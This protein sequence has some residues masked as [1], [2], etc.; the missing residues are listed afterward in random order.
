MSRPRRVLC[1]LWTVTLI[2]VTGSSAVWAADGQ[3]QVLV[4]YSTRRDAQVAVVGERELPRVLQAG[5][6]EGLDYYS[7][8][9]DR[10]RFPGTQYKEAFC[11]FL[12]LKYKDHRFDAIIAMQD[13]ALEFVG[14]NRNDLFPDTP[15]VFVGNSTAT[16]RIENS[17][18]VVDFLD[19][20]S[21]VELAASLQPDLENV[22]VV[23]GADEGSLEYADEARKQL[24]RFESRLTI[25]Y[26]TGL[27]TRALEATLSTLPPHSAVYY[28]VAN[29]DGAGLAVHPLEYLDQLAS[30]AN[31][32]TYSWVDSALE[33]G[34]V[35][36]SLK[37]QTAQ[38]VALGE[39]ALRVLRGEPADRIPLSSH[40]LNVPQVDWRQLRRWGLSE[41]RLPPGTLVKFRELSAWDRYKLYFLAALAVVLA[42]SVLIVGLLFQR[43]RRRSAEEQV[44]ES[45]TAL[46]G[47]DDRIRDLG[48][49][50]LTAQE[51]ERSHIARELHDDISQQLALL[52]IDLELLGAAGSGGALASEASSRV[53]SL[54]KSVHDLSHRLHPAKLRLIGLVA[55]INGLRREVSS[56]IP[57]TFSHEH[58]P[59][60]LPPDLTLCLFRVVQEALQ[61]AVK[62]SRASQVSV[63]LEGGPHGLALAIV[64]DGVGFNVGEAWGKGL[65]LISMRERLEAVGGTITILSTPDHGTRLE[66]AA[67]LR[68]ASDVVPA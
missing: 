1:L 11:D 8:Y 44:R 37:S 21:T 28:L 55:A 17:T 12:R 49:R 4:L 19:L 42:Q 65:G 3:K 61:N 39:V 45:Q 7:E 29:R 23:S 5:L 18:G 26:L 38:I 53:Q 16:K 48:R 30:V 50:L 36:G 25:S 35:G 22:F 33:R 68:A 46:R 59:S 10:G 40:D 47:S 66:V 20:A 13:L 58:V 6:A 57:V 34:I 52:S 67:P 60:E 62:Y 63:H 54:A 31:A 41:S 43:S 14:E 64:D 51:T 27:S 9:I 56:G 32:P 15:V 2:A 24:Q